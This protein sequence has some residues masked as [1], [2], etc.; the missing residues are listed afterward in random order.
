MPEKKFCITCEQEQVVDLITRNE[1]VTI[2]GADVTFIAQLY[3]CTI[4]NTEF[5]SPELLDANLLAAREMYSCLYE[6]FS[7]LALVELRSKYNASQKAFG[8][9]LGF[10]E[11][12]MNAYEKGSPPDSTNRLLLRLATDPYCFRKMYEI[13][14]NRIGATQRNR[15]QSSSGFVESLHWEKMDS[16]AF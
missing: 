5:E 3:R 8:L 12:T 10:G 14:K 15:I 7:P 16:V 6:C 13:H 1:T 9:I 11:L 2:K 4:C